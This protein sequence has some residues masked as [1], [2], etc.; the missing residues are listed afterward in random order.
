MKLRLAACL[1][2]SIAASAFAACSSTQPGGGDAGDASVAPLGLTPTFT[3]E[4]GPVRPLALS[5]DGTRLYVAN[6][7]NASLDVLAIGDGG[8]TL[9]GSTYVGVDPVAVAARANGEVWVVNQISDSVSV[10]DTTTTPPHVVRT[11]LV[12]DEPS[13][14]VFGGPNGSRAFVTTA[15]RGQ[16][17]TDPSIASVPGAGDPELTTPGVGRADVWVFDADNLGNTVGGTPVA[18]VTL[19]GDTP[20]ALAVTPDGQTVYAAVFKSGNQTMATSSELPCTGFDSPTQTTTCTVDGVAV[21]GAPPGP[22]TNYA[23]LPAPPV[24]M[25]LKTDGSGVWRDLLGRDWTS[26]TAFSLPDEDV[27]A[28]DATTLEPTATYLHV[29]TTLFGMAVNPVSGNVYVS[30]T[31]SRNDLRFEGPGTYA[32]QTLQGHLAESRIT[33]LSGTSVAPRYLDKHIDYSKLPA[34]PGTADHSL[35]TP[36][37]V[38]VTADGSKLYVSAFGSSKI[39]VFAT[40][41]L[42]QDTFDPTTDSGAYVSVTGGGPSGIVLDESRG[43]LYVATRFDDGVSVVD[44]ASG[45]ESSHVLLQNPE[46]A[47]VTQGRRF[48]YDATISS[49][50]GEA[51]CASCHVFGDDDHLAWDLGNPDA[52]P[53]VTPINIKLG[54]SAPLDINGTGQAASLH[55]MKGPMTTQTMRGLVN[56]G[57]MHWRGDRVSGFFG[58]DTSTGPP[59]DSTLAF[60][61]FITAF[62]TLVGLGTQFSTTDMQSFTSFAFDIVVPPN[63]VRA[64]DDSLTPAQAAG[65]AFFMGCDG[66]DSMTGQPVVCDANGAPPAGGGHFA[67][68]A[69]VANLGFTCEGC[70]VLDPSK[71]FFG[72]DGESSFE[73]L[74]QIVKVPQLRTLYDKIGMFG[75]P[76]NARTNPEDNGDQGPQVRGFGFEHDGSVDTVFRFLQAKVFD[77]TTNGKIGFTG[78]D[79]QRRNVEQFLL[80]FDNDLAP[81]VGQ[82]VTLRSD[83]VAAAGPRIDLFVA[84]AKAPFVSK[85]LGPNAHECDLVARVLASGRVVSYEMAADGTFVPDDGSAALPDPS[86][87]ALAS[88]PGQEITYTC[89]P[90]GWAQRSVP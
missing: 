11:L 29:G 89:L 3:F 55:P 85:I 7:S 6:T 45:K 12:G 84:R 64:L 46:P 5:A 26:A 27:F 68:G 10:V 16:Q 40:A 49:S 66:T 1:I 48:L 77:A 67:D 71:G 51:A 13:D 65:R 39:G 59:Y 14:I 25:I 17:R 61:N 82:Q 22:A 73:S 21:P 79:D 54:V 83:N 87:R 52:D 4:S 47:A 58:T 20:R 35:A 18:I 44:L 69:A 32:G 63:P 78:G 24:A 90:P 15:H 33:V 86:L 8:L 41:A 76:P 74:P 56:H 80:A 60:E 50:N 2:G 34:P 31:E 53:T 30:N 57:P 23:G 42:E 72:T 38:A 37:D 70:H 9:V 36:L 88:T 81:I 75:A 43:R 28:I 19:F 62:N